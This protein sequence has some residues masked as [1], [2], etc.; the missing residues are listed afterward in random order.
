[1]GEGRVLVVMHFDDTISLKT[2]PS[3]YRQR[4]ENLDFQ[5]LW[6]RTLLKEGDKD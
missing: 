5:L 6:C 2:L 3:H 1:M 4:V